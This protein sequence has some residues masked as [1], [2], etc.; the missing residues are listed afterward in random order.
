M[1]QSLFS[2]AVEGG[3]HFDEVGPEARSR[4]HRTAL[5]EASLASATRAHRDHTAGLDHSGH[6]RT[7][8]SL[9]TPGVLHIRMTAHRA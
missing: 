6:P 8:N 3:R 2:W 5:R 1:E 9:D 7:V 4:M